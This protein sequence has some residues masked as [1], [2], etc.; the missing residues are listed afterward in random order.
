MAS[1]SISSMEVRT[2]SAAYVKASKIRHKKMFP[3]K[4]PLLVVLLDNA[5]AVLLLVRQLPAEP[6]SAAGRPFAAAAFARPTS[7]G[8]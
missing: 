3:H 7:K 1:H 2:A 4:N 6:E 8:M 5:C